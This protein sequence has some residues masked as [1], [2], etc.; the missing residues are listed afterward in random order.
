MS[1]DRLAEQLPHL[2]L[3]PEAA[4][5][6]QRL[7][8]GEPATVDELA[9]GTGISLDEVKERVAQ[10]VEA[11]LAG[12]VGTDQIAPLPPEAGLKILTA[13]REAELLQATVAA[14]QAYH[15]YLRSLQ[16]P[17]ENDVVEIVSG[18]AIRERIDQAERNVRHEIR[19]LDSPPHYTPQLANDLE[20]EHLAAGIRYRVVYA[21]AS[22]A[23]DGYYDANI[24]PCLD[25][26]EHARVLPEVPVKL[27]IIDDTMAL[28]GL[29]IGE[30][31][32]NHSLIIVRPSSLFSA[33]VGL[34]DLCWR[35]AL[36]MQAAGLPAPRLEPVEQRLLALLAA[37]LTDDAIT[38]KLGVSRRTFFRY[39]ERLQVQAGVG[40]R[41]QLGMHA[42]REGW[43]D[44]RL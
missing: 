19:R 3:D 25:A 28:I 16:S 6:Y 37:G 17:V 13:R 43:L 33:L 9:D 29:P 40:T 27:S 5:V 31:D 36:P 24:Q 20:L 30:A 14:Q 7:L 35:N 10:L 18:S 41:F 39:L 38:R 15:E 8:T 21:Q 11:G 23:L 12:S 1:S 2:G 26:G 4:L 42:V 34:F 22:V 32:V 44:R